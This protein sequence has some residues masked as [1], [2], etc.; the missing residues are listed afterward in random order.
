MKIK[1]DAFEA[2]CLL[3]TIIE[4]LFIYLFSAFHLSPKKDKKI[5][6]FFEYLTDKIM[7]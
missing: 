6:T 4:I 7:C 5:I 2:V 3:K 1:A